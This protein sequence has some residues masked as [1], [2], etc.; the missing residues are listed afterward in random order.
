MKKI[1]AWMFIF[2]LV[3]GACAVAEGTLIGQ[4]LP[5]FT[6]ST[7]D[8]GQITL[9]KVLG[10][11]DLVVVNLFASW[12][13][14]CY[15]EF[16][17][18]QSAY[19]ALSERMEVIALSAE[20]TDTLQILSEYRSQ[21]GLKFPVGPEEG[22]GLA[23]FVGLTAF[24]TTL[25]VDGSGIVNYMQVGAFVNRRQFESVAEWFLAEDYDGTA[26]TAYN[27]YVCDQDGA[28]VPGV[29]VLFC[30]DTACTPMTTDEQ[31]VICFAGPREAYDLK[32]LAAPD[33]YSFDPEAVTAWDSSR[34]WNGLTVNLD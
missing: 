23:E 8:G 12:C 2:S 3:L 7:T 26:P 28:M 25:F 22:T 33:D 17:E 9:S 4:T 11:K 32:I 10:Q 31:G 21:L 16:P 27:V 5:D 19:D 30:T 6:A 13:P 14:P 18:I 24:P 34:I 20:P 15:A 29:T 1:I